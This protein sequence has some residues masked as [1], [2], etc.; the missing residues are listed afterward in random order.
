MIGGGDFAPDRLVP[1]AMRAFSAGRT[2]EIRN[3]LSVRPWQHV[4]EPLCG[5]LLL[6][7]RLH[8][9]GAFA[10]GWNFGPRTDESAPVQQV[11]DLLASHWGEG[12]RWSQDPAAHPHEAATLKLDSTKARTELGW[13]P[14]LS[15][16]DALR[17]TVAWYRSFYDGADMRALTDRQ[18]ADYLT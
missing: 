12:A 16:E 4:L 11:A 8:D 1:D 5:Y 9:E 17:L 14:R 7:E 18:V 10:Q 2:L 6:A 3:P 13:T 15:L